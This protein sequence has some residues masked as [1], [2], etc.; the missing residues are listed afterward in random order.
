ML[1]QRMHKAVRAPDAKTLY[2]ETYE[3]KD[4]DIERLDPDVYSDEV[5]EVITR[6]T[7]VHDSGDPNAPVVVDPDDYEAMMLGSDEEFLENVEVAVAVAA[8]AALLDDHRR[9]AYAEGTISKEM[10]INLDGSAKVKALDV[11][12]GEAYKAAL[13]EMQQDR[14][15]FS[16][17]GDGELRSADGTKTFISQVRSDAFTEAARRINGQIGDGN[18]RVF[19]EQDVT[20]DDLQ[21]LATV[22]VH[23]A[24]YMFLA[25]LPSWE[26]LADGSFDRAMAVEMKSTQ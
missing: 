12:I 8:N 24:F 26:V 21:S 22:K 19:A 9:M 7:V 13:V 4:V 11:E 5:M 1:D 17:G 14:K 6:M 16:V 3:Y 23:T 10:L 18:S 20:E 2:Q 15:H 25:T